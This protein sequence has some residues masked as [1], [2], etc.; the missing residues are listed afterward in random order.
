[1]KSNTSRSTERSAVFSALGVRAAS[2]CLGA[3]ALLIAAMNPALAPASPPITDLSIPSTGRVFSVDAISGGGPLPPPAG[4]VG[5]DGDAFEITFDFVGLTPS[6]EAVFET[7]AAIWDLVITGYQ[8]DSTLGGPVVFGGTGATGPVITAGALSAMPFGDPGGVLA[9]GG[10]STLV[11]FDLADPAATDFVLSESGVVF[12]DTADIGAL[13]SSGALL[14]VALHEI[15]HVLGI[16]TL[17]DTSGVTFVDGSGSVIDINGQVVSV[18]GSGTFTGEAGLAAFNAEFDPEG[19]ATVVPIEL[20]GGPGTADA[21][22][23][24]TTA[25]T[26]NITGLGLNQEI[27][28]GFLGPAPNFLSTLSVASL[29][30]IGFTVDPTFQS[31]TIAELA[32]IVTTSA[33]PEPTGAV[34]LIAGFAPLMAKRRRG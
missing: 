31:A 15:G 11:A 2:G 5:G 13:E 27:L 7:A 33:V 14:D 3:F 4:S 30:D 22:F 19:D 29:E 32:A 28:T 1:M 24:E 25:F 12:V 18:A 9:A 16:G 21:H 17:W 10:V 8:V 23:D 26:S 6:Q 20:E 34:L